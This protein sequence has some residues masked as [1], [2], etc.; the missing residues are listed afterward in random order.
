V[1][2]RAQHKWITGVSCLPGDASAGSSL[3]LSTLLNIY[4][5]LLHGWALAVAAALFRSLA[6]AARRASSHHNAAGVISA[7]H[8]EYVLI[9]WTHQMSNLVHTLRQVVN[10]FFM[11]KKSNR[12]CVD[13]DVKSRNFPLNDEKCFLLFSL[14]ANFL[15]MS[16]RFII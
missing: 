3:S 15:K 10:V 16:Y 9:C 2:F 14:V 4:A 11:K 8:L 13:L 7:P 12:R 1:K 6:D 5:A